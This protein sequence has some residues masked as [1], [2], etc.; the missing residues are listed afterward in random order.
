MG[1]LVELRSSGKLAMMLST[2]EN[3]MSVA[4]QPVDNTLHHQPKT[5]PIETYQMEIINIRHRTR[6]IPR[7]QA[8]E[9]ENVR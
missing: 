2:V 4:S 1:L 6:W 5:F 7:H 8:L 9:S 3:T